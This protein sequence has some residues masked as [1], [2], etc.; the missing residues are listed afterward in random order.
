MSDCCNS[1]CESESKHAG[2]PVKQVCPACQ[3]LASKVSIRTIMHHLK[4][5]WQ[6]QLTEEQY[7]FC[8]T[9]GCDVVY[10][11]ANGEKLN[12]NDIRTQV[13]IKEHDEQGLVCYCFGVTRAMAKGDKTIKEFVVEQTRTA[14]CAC[15]TANPSGKCCLKDFPGT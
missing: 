7:Y 5:A 9:L 8:R 2:K 3:E 12:K 10:F 4:Q 11:S 1:V 15:E 14:M 13:G 6:H